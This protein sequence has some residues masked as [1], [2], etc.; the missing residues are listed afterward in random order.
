MFARRLDGFDQR[1]VKPVVM[2]KRNAP[3][4][5][6]LAL[7]RPVPKILIGVNWEKMDWVVKGLDRPTFLRLKNVEWEINLFLN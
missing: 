6:R 1:A 7:C 4:R 3:R 5:I 2:V